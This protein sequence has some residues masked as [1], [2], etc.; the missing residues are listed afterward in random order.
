MAQ[1]Q[2]DVLAVEGLRCRFTIF[3][4]LKEGSQFLLVAGTTPGQQGSP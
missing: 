2:Q 3:P 1:Y 4:P